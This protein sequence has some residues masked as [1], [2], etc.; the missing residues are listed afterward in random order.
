MSDNRVSVRT[1]RPLQSYQSDVEYDC[2]DQCKNSPWSM[3][4]SIWFHESEIGKKR[5]SSKRFFLFVISERA[6]ER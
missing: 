3:K 2:A 4:Q 5:H 6:M 1:I